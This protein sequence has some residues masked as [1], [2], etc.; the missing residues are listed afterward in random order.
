MS[1]G[2][3]FF[4]S[5][6]IMTI[7]VIDEDKYRDFANSFFARQKREISTETFSTLYHLVDGQTWYV[8]KILNR[9]YRTPK[10]ALDQPDV[11]GAV[12]KIIGEL[13]INYQSNYNLLTENQALLLT[14]IAREGIVKA[15]TALDFVMRYRLPAPSSIKQ[16]I[17]SLLEKEFLYQDPKLGYMVYD[18]F[19]GMWLKRLME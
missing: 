16:A 4:N 9:L 15:P 12:G 19:F 7:G 17:K 6:Q 10:G 13:E 5:S 14:A 11:L 8:Q 18:R 1:P 3:P 2:H